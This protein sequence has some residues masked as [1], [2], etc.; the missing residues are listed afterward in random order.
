MKQQAFR[1][2]TRL[3]LFVILAATSA[4]A[5]AGAPQ[6]ANVPFDFIVGSQTLPAGRYI[7]ERINR[8]TI[9]ETI[10]L[11]TAEGRAIMMVR[12]MPAQARSTQQQA[13]L[14]FPRYGQRYFLSQLVTPGDDFRLKLPKSR[15]ERTLE[16][17]LVGS[18]QTKV[19]ASVTV[20]LGHAGK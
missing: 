17:E 14:I 10:L 12:T 1:T 15:F 19:T 5:Q 13:R 20:A 18:N 3:G 8:Q 11:R 16:R 9:Q 6:Q 7:F 2:M 4:Y